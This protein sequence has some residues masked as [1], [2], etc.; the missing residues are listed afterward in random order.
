MR[1]R[2]VLAA[3]AGLVL[4]F[5]APQ[6]SAEGPKPK[7]DND[8]YVQLLAFNDFHGNLLPPGGSSGRI[9]ISPT[10]NVNAG[11]VAFLATH[12]KMLREQ[13]SNTITV[14]AGDLIGASPLISGLFHDEPTIESMNLLGLDVSGVGNH[15]FDEGVNEL[16]RMQFGGCHP[17]DGCQ[18][19]SP[20]AGAY[21]QYLA[22]NVFY[23]GTNTTIL[24]PYEIKKI[25]N[26]KI[27]FIGLTLE[28]TPLIVT[29]AGV[30]GL[31]FRPEVQTVNTLVQKL[32]AEQGVRAF[33]VLIHQGGQQN[34][35]FA[36]GFQD[37]NR[38]DNFSGD[39]KAIVDGLDSQ[40]DVVISAHTHQP[41][42]CTINDKVV[43]SASSFGRLITDVD[44]VIDH[45]SKDVKSVT[46]RNVIVTRGVTED[47]DQ[48][49]LIAKYD[50]ISGP[51]K[52]RVVGSISADI[53]RSPNT[54]QESALGDVIAD[55]QL[56]STS[57][58]D[59]GGAVVAFMNPGGIRGDLVCPPVAPALVCPAASYP[60]SV[61]YGQLFDVQPFNNVMV[62]KTMTGQQ[63]YNL[64]AQQFNNPSVGRLRVLQVSDGFT[65]S[66]SFTGANPTAT[67]PVPGV[68]TVAPGSVRI[69]GVAVD[70]L[71]SY[72]VAM[73][74]FL[75]SGGDG[76]TVFNQG[77]NQLGGE[78]DLDAL[79]NYFGGNS[80]VAPGPQNRITRL[81]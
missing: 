41:Y 6:A 73:N 27:A 10:T 77:T 54:A 49:A 22:A 61:T 31:E 26:A 37:I 52:N 14:G 53:S 39:I 64:L 58:T 21:F 62:V 3:M 30:A 34:A 42:I 78:I 8:T 57:P 13:N 9:A 43:T 2:T 7:K 20:F 5:A 25:D 16:L 19:G 33:V 55:A 71:A 48:V 29:P 36:N 51:I 28:G 66:Y 50:A 38:C 81:P 69:K 75:A 72:R 24:P 4:A 17:V 67:P 23:A 44:L 32:R 35:P 11:G 74:N 70:P 79:V 18:D 56:A 59:F 47:A 40:V 46:A 76:F 80:P 1:R 63:I 45:Q 68:G 12:V 60:S 65:Y 15:E